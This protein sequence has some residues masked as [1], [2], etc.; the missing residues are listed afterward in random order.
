[1]SE[2]TTSGATPGPSDREVFE[3]VRTHL[4][5]QGRRARTFHGDGNCRYRTWA[6]DGSVLMCAAGCLIAEAAYDESLEGRN[7]GNPDVNR[8][9]VESG[10]LDPAEAS[11]TAERSPRLRMLRALQEVHDRIEV[12]RWESVLAG[13]AGRLLT[14]GGSWTGRLG[15]EDAYEV[16]AD[17]PAGASA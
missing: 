7:V 8:A 17:A 5:R 3:R 6:E 11:V 1:M 4:L 9:L 2:T 10:V 15:A 14:P 13:L 16:D 12:S